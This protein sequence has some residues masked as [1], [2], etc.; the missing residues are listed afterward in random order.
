MLD[1]ALLAR[2]AGLKNILVSSGYINQE[3]LVELC[4]VIDGPI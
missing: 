2:K 1:T 4:K 3:P